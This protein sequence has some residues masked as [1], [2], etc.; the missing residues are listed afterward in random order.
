LRL[1]EVETSLSSQS[2]RRTFKIK[3]VYDIY[4]IK[5]SMYCKKRPQL[6]KTLETMAEQIGKDLAL[7]LLQQAF[8]KKIRETDAEEMEK[9]IEPSKDLFGLISK[10][11]G[12]ISAYGKIPDADVFQKLVLQLLQ[13][14]PVYDQ[15]F[16]FI[17]QRTTDQQRETRLSF[18]PVLSQLLVLL[19][20]LDLAYNL[21]IDLHQQYNTEL[22]NSNRGFPYEPQFSFQGTELQ[23]YL[24]IGKEIRDEVSQF[25]SRKRRPIGFSDQKFYLKYKESFEILEKLPAIARKADKINEKGCPPFFAICSSSGT[26]KTQLPFTL[27]VPLLYFV[28]YQTGE[29]QTI[30]G[31]FDSASAALE[32]V[33][34]NDYQLFT[35]GFSDK[36]LDD[37]ENFTATKLFN[38][39]KAFETS[40]F[41]VDLIV[42]I[43]NLKKGNP[44]EPWAKLQLHS[45]ISINR[46]KLSIKDARIQLVDCF[47]KHPELFEKCQ[48]LIF[49]DEFNISQK[50]DSKRQG[51]YVFLKNMIR[52]LLL[53][54]VLMGTNTNI[55]NMIT[56][57]S[58]S[59]H[60]HREIWCYLFVSLPKTPLSFIQKEIKSL[61][62]SIE[63]SDVNNQKKNFLENIKPFMI[64]ERPFFVIEILDFLKDKLKRFELK[65]SSS[66]CEFI[67]FLFCCLSNA[68][69]KRKQNHL[70]DFHRC[71]ICYF[72]NEYTQRLN[73][74]EYPE[75]I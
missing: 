54:P 14:N 31:D 70:K 72:E 16:N 36:Q 9:L 15:I 51:Q 48:P 73:P 21:V 33:S 61:S 38:F 32:T 12:G 66:M 39:T 69:R 50:S 53:I 6:P 28:V 75:L 47:E 23:K 71:Q 11:Q 30:Y 1:H 62:A 56:T 44:D 42:Q 27:D 8:D 41:L 25:V 64:R 26:G 22:Y 10:F 52:A 19:R 68:F 5:T 60:N 49:L 24:N 17:V 67:V 3:R 63:N 7:L 18:P 29:S 74:G 37:L 35:R 43:S 4:G 59:G 58:P 2:E 34:K 46:R 57:G 55:S 40:G 20:E 65:E 13:E 45:S